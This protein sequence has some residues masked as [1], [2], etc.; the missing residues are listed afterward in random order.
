LSVQYQGYSNQ[1]YDYKN[2]LS[3]GTT[4]KGGGKVKLPVAYREISL[5][6]ARLLRRGKVRDIFDLDDKLLIVA[7][8]RISA[9]DVVLPDAIPYKGKVLNSISAFWFRKLDHIIPN[10][11]ISDNSGDFPFEATDEEKGILQGRSSVVRK[12]EM[13]E[14]ECVIRGYL[15]GSGWKSYTKTGKL[16]DLSL[17]RGLKQGDRLPEPLFTPT[18]KAKSGHD[19]PIRI[20]KLKD[21]LG[22]QAALFLKEKSTDLYRAAYAHC[23]DRGIILADT[24]FEFAYI[25]GEIRLA[26]EIFTPDS[27]RFWDRESYRPGGPQPSF[28]KQYIRD[29]LETQDWDKT[30]PAPSLPQNVIERTVEKY[31]DVFRKITG[32]NLGT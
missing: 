30:P 10:H 18:T 12:G 24:K 20:E 19:E 26:D 5:S 7:S 27:S 29:W 16:F 13:I 14:I 8:D 1:I 21:R 22:V 6:G 3:C 32:K 2:F 17:P 31:L 25:D 23:F 28:D 9:F 4:R 11:F 15:D